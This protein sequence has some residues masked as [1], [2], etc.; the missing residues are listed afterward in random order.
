[1][2]F[3][4]AIGTVYQVVD[5]QELLGQHVLN[6]YFYKV[7]LSVLGAN[8]HDVTAAFIDQMLPTIH[9]CQSSQLVHTSV[10]AQNLFDV[11]DV[12]EELISVAGSDGD[13]VDN[14]FDA[15]AVRMTGD[16]GAV[17]SGAKRIAALRDDAI[18]DGVIVDT[19]LLDHLN[20]LMA[21]IATTLLWGTLDGGTLVPVIVQRILDAG[22]Y[23]LPTNAGEAV[24]STIVDALFSPLI[25][26]Q[27][28]RKI[29]RG[30]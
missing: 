4:A 18:A 19:T 7:T 10:K 14:T 16:N 20:D 27:V 1:M 23:R 13:T 17:R 12:H 22:A 6:V 24:L 29:G 11:S 5:N 26:S 15:C 25:S 30:E 28:S 21:E 2:K 9:P 8:A 3:V